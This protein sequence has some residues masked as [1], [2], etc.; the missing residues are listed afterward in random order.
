M[1]W[2]DLVQMAWN[3]LSRNRARSLMTLLGVT[4]GAAALVTLLA[5]GSG[6]QHN[7]RA[8]FEAL[9]LYNTLRVT[10]RPIPF[11]GPGDL[12]YRT[13][14]RDSLADRPAVALTDSVVTALGQIPGVLAAYPEIQ[15]PVRIQ[16]NGREIAGGVDAVPMAF[17]RLRA[18]QPRWGRFFLHEADTAIIL[19]TSMAQRLGF[20]RPEE[21]VGSSVQIL[22]AAIDW[23]ALQQ[24]LFGGWYLSGGELPIRIQPYRVQI[25]GLLDADDQAFAG[26]FRVLM[27]LGLSRRLETVTFFSTVDLL[28]RR[29]GVSGYSAVRVHLEDPRLH[30]SVR[31]RIAEMGL[32][33]TSFREQFAE[34]DRLFWLIDMALFVIGI[35]ALLVATIGIAN[36]MRMSVMERFRE[37]GIL[38][39]LG[40]YERDIQ[41]IFLLESALLGLAGGLLGW[42]I[43]WGLA[44]LIEL[45]VNVYLARRGVPAVD[46]FYF[47]PGLILFVG[48]LTLL[49]GLLAGWWP[50]RQAARVD[51]LVALRQV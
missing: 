13:L 2:Y 35:I 7:A 1:Y 21:A 44:E 34:L 39:A 5:Y 22:V 3:G 30:D 32:Y 9:E 37:I 40:A 26:F 4:I 10:S 24:M 33:V 42:L 23:A 41:R 16:A 47:T 12:L 14:E 43:G 15:F 8:Q 29:A 19:S 28:F 36:T 38:K 11:S 50:A 17:G 51:V 48:I 20:S 18:Y 27:P 49:T 46:L 45:G 31:R 25:R 6:L